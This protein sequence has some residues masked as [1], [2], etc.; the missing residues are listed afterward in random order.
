VFHKHITSLCSLSAIKSIRSVLL[1]LRSV[2]LVLYRYCLDIYCL[3]IS[4][5]RLRSVAAEEMIPEIL[6]MFLSYKIDHRT[7]EYVHYGCFKKSMIC[8]RSMADHICILESDEKGI[9][10]FI[11]KLM[12]EHSGNTQMSS[13][14]T[15]LSHRIVSCR[16]E[17]FN[18]IVMSQALSC[19]PCEEERRTIIALGKRA[20]LV[21]IFL[22]LQAVH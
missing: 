7:I 1:R 22:I 8:M 2:P 17:T 9:C 14:L 12:D 20:T 15:S 18:R 10:W 21:R 16:S 3:Y 11:S 19:Y 5:Y 4:F 6:W 13:L